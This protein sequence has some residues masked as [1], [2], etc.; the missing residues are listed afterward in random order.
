MTKLLVPSIMLALAACVSGGNGPLPKL[1]HDPEQPV[2][3]LFEH[4]L[5]AHFAGAGAS[6]PATCAR[7]EP[8]PLTAAQE[9]ALIERFARLS[10]ASQCG[11][12]DA[13]VR[14]YGFACASDALCGGWAT[15]PGAPAMRYAM[16][17]VDGAW[18]FDGD[19]RVIAE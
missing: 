5:T 16:R 8:E 13:A 2:L 12:G 14:V 15:R 4:V 19:M 11:E 3:A 7:L 9:K 17:F 10:P 18:R 6:G 1:A